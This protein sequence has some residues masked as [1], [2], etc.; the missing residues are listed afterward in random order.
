MDIMIGR[1]AYKLYKLTIFLTFSRHSLKLAVAL[2]A[3][4]LFAYLVYV[5]L[6]TLAYCCGI[7]KLVHLRWRVPTQ[8]LILE[9]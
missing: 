7:G 4:I 6:L 8:I 5:I 9:P 1:C 2:C 3:I